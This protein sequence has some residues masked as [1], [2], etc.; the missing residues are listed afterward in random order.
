MK[1]YLFDAQTEAMLNRAENTL[2]GFWQAGQMEKYKALCQRL[3]E[4]IGEDE[5]ETVKMQDMQKKAEEGQ[6]MA[7]W[8]TARYLESAGASD[9]EYLVEMLCRDFPLCGDKKLL[10]AMLRA[11]KERYPALFRRQLQGVR[12]MEGMMEEEGREMTLTERMRM[13]QEEPERYQAIFR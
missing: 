13:Y 6:K 2:R 9:G 10:E 7:K 3:R 12:P 11:A 1:Q 4:M 8:Y 5:E